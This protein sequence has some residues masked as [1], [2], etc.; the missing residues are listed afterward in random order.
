MKTRRRSAR[1]ASTFCSSWRRSRSRAS[2][3]GRSDRKASTAYS[4]AQARTAFVG[5]PSFGS[6]CLLNLG[7]VLRAWRDTG[8]LTCKNIL[9]VQQSPACFNAMFGCSVR[10]VNGSCVMGAR[11]AGGI[12]LVL[13]CTAFLASPLLH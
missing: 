9:M 6:L 12:F 2:S 1:P 11:S 4:D 10:L 3:D 7:R 5:E 13:R 8:F